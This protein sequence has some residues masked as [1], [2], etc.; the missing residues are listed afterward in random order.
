MIKVKK[1]RVTELDALRGIAAMVVVL[2]HY[3]HMSKELIGLNLGIDRVQ[4]LFS[5]GQYGV[6]L[7]FVISGFVIFMTAEKVSNP[8]VFLKKRAIRL[9]PSYWLCS[10]I[11]FLTVI[12]LGPENLKV[13]F[14][15][16]LVNLT[17]VP[18]VFK[19]PNV[20]GVYWTLK[21]EIF[22]YLV[23]ASIMLV[24]QLNKATFIIYVYFLLGVLIFTLLRPLLYYYYGLLSILGINFYQLWKKDKQSFH[25]LFQVILVVLGAFF[26][27]T[28]FLT[29]T[30]IF[31]LFI[32]N[33]LQFLNIK[34][35]LLLGRISYVLYLIHQNVGYTI[36]MHLSKYT[37]NPFLL[38]GCPLLLSVLASYVITYF[39]ERPVQR[40]ISRY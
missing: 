26:Y 20:D 25:N 24:K 35:L 17:M 36:Q 9:Y 33:K 18:D 7:F 12:F 30:V 39:Y 5:Y 8:I 23:I 27:G 34:V 4:T 14:S 1:N 32:F 11:T 2:F 15:D 28:T 10:L 16:F 6:H 37:N 3:V 38:V 40:F 29:L 22:F 31:Y 13:N 19:V 21:I